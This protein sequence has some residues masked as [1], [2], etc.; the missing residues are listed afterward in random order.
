[1][2]FLIKKSFKIILGVIASIAITALATVVGIKCKQYKHKKLAGE[3][4]KCCFSLIE[5]FN[6]IYYDKYKK[7][8]VIK[9][10]DLSVTSREL[11]N[12]LN[13]SN[14]SETNESETNEGVNNPA[15][16]LLRCGIHKFREVYAK[17]N[18]IPAETLKDIF[19]TINNFYLET[20]CTDEQANENFAGI[21]L[22]KGLTG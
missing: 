5:E 12:A 15:S 20:G 1:M 17:E 18:V 16:I 6:Y 14:L 19:N 4:S 7:L 3:S 10:D 2:L 8:Q 21:C 13:S 11:I 22:T 9:F